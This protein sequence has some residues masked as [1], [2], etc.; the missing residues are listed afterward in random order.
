M[1]YFI[2]CIVAIFGHFENALISR[3]LPVFQSRFFAQNKLNVFAETFFICLREFYFLSQTEYFAWAIAFAL[4]PFL[5]IFKMLSFLEYQLFF[6]A[7]FCVEQVKCVCRNAF[8]KMQGIL[9][10][11]PKLS[12][13]HGLQPLHCGHFLAIFKMFSSFEYQLFFGLVFWIEP[14]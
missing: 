2:L 13:L 1:G 12:N 6:R 8:Y 14:R 7:V 9:F 4:W 3:I 10:F 5:A 11:D